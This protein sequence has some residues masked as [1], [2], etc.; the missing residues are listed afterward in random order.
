MFG[1]KD[2]DDDDPD[3]AETD[4]T[5][6]DDADGD[7]DAE[8]EQWAPVLHLQQPLRRPVWRPLYQ[9]GWGGEERR[10]VVTGMYLSLR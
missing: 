3:K 9:R 7:G 10:E 2:P 8:A 1:H 6:D 5:S 4:E